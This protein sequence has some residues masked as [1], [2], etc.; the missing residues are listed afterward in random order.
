MT[1]INESIAQIVEL[2]DSVV[3]QMKNVEEAA[4][5][6]KE[7]SAEVQAK[8]EMLFRLSQDLNRTVADFKV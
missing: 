3:Q 5:F 6:S 2:I 7:G 1:G 8:M 4:G